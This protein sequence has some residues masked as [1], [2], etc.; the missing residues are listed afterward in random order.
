MDRRFPSRRELTAH[1]PMQTLHALDLT[2]VPASDSQWRRRAAAGERVSA[3]PQSGDA[4]ELP[5]GGIHSPLG[6]WFA[7]A[8]SWKADA[9][10][11]KIEFCPAGEKDYGAS[12]RD[13][14][15]RDGASS[16][17][18]VRARVKS[19]T[20][21]GQA[22]ARRSTFPL[23][24]EINHETARVGVDADTWESVQAPVLLAVAQFWRFGAIDRQLDELSDWA[25]A[26]LATTSG[27]RSVIRRR[28][29]RDLRAHWRTLQALILDL[30]DFEA[31]LTNPRSCLAPGRSIRLYRAL[32][33][34]LGLDRWRREI[35]ERIEVVEATFDSLVESLNHHQSL[36][37]QV[38]LELVIVAVLFLDAGLFLVDALAQK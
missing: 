22:R 33:A 16:C 29:A 4:L 32:A 37:F 5:S 13:C 6:Y 21:S 12:T 35:D 7:A 36:V 10:R 28:R 26:D 18:T 14:R 27:F 17:R 25:R 31:A 34:R 3:P 24:I 8:Q 30:P 38:A 15:S 1:L 2:K 23:T 19:A 9:P 20:T 11:L